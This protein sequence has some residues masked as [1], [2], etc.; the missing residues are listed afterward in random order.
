MFSLLCF[1]RSLSFLVYNINSDV[2]LIDI[3]FFPG[4]YNNSTLLIFFINSFKLVEFFNHT[5][6]K[7]CSANDDFFQKIS[8]PIK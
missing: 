8:F 5:E 1:I 4:Q 2:I 3:I 7:E 6:D